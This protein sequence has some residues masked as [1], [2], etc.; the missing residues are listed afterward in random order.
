[1]AES[2]KAIRSFTGRG[3]IHAV[4]LVAHRADMDDELWNATFGP[5]ISPPT[6]RATNSA[7]A[8]KLLPIMTKK[9]MLEL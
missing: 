7:A 1:M 8:S 6:N 3:S 4:L 2:N 5:A 9:P